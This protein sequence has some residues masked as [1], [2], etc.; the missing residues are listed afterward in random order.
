[1]GATLR[2]RLLVLARWEPVFADPG[3]VP[4]KWADIGPRPDGSIQMPWF[5]Y[6]EVIDRFRA[7]MAGHGWVVPFDWMAWA[8][9][10]E[11]R[12]LISDPS[13]VSSA[14]ADDLARLLTTI[15]RGERFSDGEIAGAHESGHLLAI[16][17]RAGVLAEELPGST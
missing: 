9:S 14:S 16:A 7:D 2:E 6:G 4:G 1:M 8:A 5:E 10:P 13:R 11:G 15:I 17:R 3:F 12:R